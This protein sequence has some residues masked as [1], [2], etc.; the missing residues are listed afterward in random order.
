LEGNNEKAQK[1]FL[2]VLDML[3]ADEESG[4]LVS[5]ELARLYVKMNKL[6]EA[7][8]YAMEEYKIRPNNIDVNRELAVIAYKEKDSARFTEYLKAASRTGSK[9]PELVS[10][11]AM[12]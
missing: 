9:D 6:D 8:K 7:K 11:M 12:K 3:K 2:E 1:K 4:H 10:L 5:L